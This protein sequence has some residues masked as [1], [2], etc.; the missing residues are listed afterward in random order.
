MVISYTLARVQPSRD[1]EVFNQISQLPEV[2][3]VITTYG[4]YDVIVKVEVATLSDLDEFV[5]HKLRTI[6]GVESTTTLIK[7]AIP[8]K[9]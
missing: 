1:V 8:P 6:V 4:E 3:D 7:A 2:R 5:F 9:R